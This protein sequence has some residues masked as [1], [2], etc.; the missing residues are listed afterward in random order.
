[1]TLS[2]HSDGWLTP[3]N[4]RF[5]RRT[6]QRIPGTGKMAVIRRHE[7]GREAREPGLAGAARTRPVAKAK[8]FGEALDEMGLVPLD[9]PRRIIVREGHAQEPL[10][11]WRR[12]KERD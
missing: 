1:L 3:A 12:P 11:R 10:T 8:T 2:G 4:L 5:I 6:G 7:R 9:P